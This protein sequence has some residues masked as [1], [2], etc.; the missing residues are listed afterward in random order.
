M[1]STTCGNGTW[2]KTRTCSNP[3]PSKGGKPCPGSSL[4]TGVC[5]LRECPGM[6]D[7]MYCL[8][9]DLVPLN[10]L[11]TVLDVLN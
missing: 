4:E 2:T 3:A 6:F 10:S 9:L 8:L 1:C 5:N 7:Q 11:Q